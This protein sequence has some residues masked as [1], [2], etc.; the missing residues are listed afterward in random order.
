MA[1]AERVEAATGPDREIDGS[2]WWATRSANVIEHLD[3]SGF[4]RRCIKRDGSAGR[5]L[6]QFFDSSNPACL[7][8]LAFSNAYT[9]SIDAA[10][11]LVPEGLWA[12]GSLGS[13]VDQRASLEI[14]APC[15]YDPIGRATAA[16]PALALTAAALRARAALLSDRGEG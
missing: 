12:E 8:R 1:L 6:Q 10:M 3:P 9:A 13:H 2:I 11:T 14:H 5:A 7:A 16:T 4:V 15:T